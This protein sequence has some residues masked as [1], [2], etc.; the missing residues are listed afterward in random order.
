[1]LTNASEYARMARAEGELWWYRALH[2]LVLKAVAAHPGGVE[3]RILDAGCGTGGLMQCLARQGYHNVSG[4]DLSP[5][6]IQICR[7]RGL[8][9][10]QGDLRDFNGGSSKWDIIVSNDTLCYFSDPTIQE[11][12][13]QSFWQLLEPGGLLILNL[14]ALRCFRGRHDRAV[15]ILRRFSPED[16]PRLLK[17]VDFEVVNSRFWPFFISPLIFAVRWV[18]R[19]EM[20]VS[21]SEGA[22]V[23]DAYLPPRWLNELFARITRFETTRLRAVPFGSSL[24]IVAGKLGGQVKD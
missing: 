21:K 4:F 14:P 12:V 23:S 19:L 13:V 24:F 18:Q 7:H 3:A 16:V 10:C 9:A 2:N 17:P 5:L 8:D 1:M 15:G 11:H 20:A 6:A 22:P